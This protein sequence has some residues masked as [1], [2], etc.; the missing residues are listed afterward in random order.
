LIKIPLLLPTIEADTTMNK[1]EYDIAI[2]G[3]GCAGP[4]AAKKAAELGLK[5]L[6]LEKSQ[7][8]MHIFILKLTQGVLGE[9]IKGKAEKPEISYEMTTE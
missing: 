5:V 3:A 2:V 4:T 9:V 7:I 6:L 8:L 1:N